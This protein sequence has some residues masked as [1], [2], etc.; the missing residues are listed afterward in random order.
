MAL[1]HARHVLASAALAV[2]V[3]WFAEA[4]DPAA[5]RWVRISEPNRPIACDVGAIVAGM[6]G[7]QT[8]WRCVRYR[9]M[10]PPVPPGDYPVDQSRNR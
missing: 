4:R 8:Q 9:R 3:T 6:W 10:P 7:P 2:L 5:N 1:R